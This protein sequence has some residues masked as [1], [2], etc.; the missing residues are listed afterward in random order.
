M[1][2]AILIWIFASHAVAVPVL[3]PIAEEPAHVAGKHPCLSKEQEWFE[4]NHENAT[5]TMNFRW[6][7]A[8]GRK[9]HMSLRISQRSGED[10]EHQ[11]SKTMD[12]IQA[13]D[14]QTL[15]SSDVVLDVGASVGAFAVAIALHFPRARIIA[16]EP[17]PQN[18]R[19]LLW[20][21]RLNNVSR[22]VWP[23]NIAVRGPSEDVVLELKYSPIWWTASSQCPLE[24]QEDC[25]AQAT[26]QNFKS[27]TY[28]P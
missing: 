6:R 9:V 16:I 19:Y 25:D 10:E 7:T 26:L 21:I 15:F 14:G 20:N 8:R 4:A 13:L 17:A 2:H 22:R 12:Y 3:G 27:M 23:M 11:F 28:L 24:V 5:R 18:F 1:H